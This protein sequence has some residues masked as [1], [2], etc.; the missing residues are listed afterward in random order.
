[1]KNKMYAGIMAAV[2]IGLLSG[3]SVNASFNQGNSV[4]FNGQPVM[5]ILASGGGFSPERR[6]W[7]AQDALDNAL[8]LSNDPGPQSVSVDLK[9]GA[10]VVNFDGHYIATADSGSAM[11]AGMSPAALANKWADSLKSALNDPDQ[12]RDYVASLK[13]PHQL[14]G[15]VAVAYERTIYAPQGT[16]LPVSFNEALNVSTLRSGQQ[17]TARVTANVP[18]GNYFIPGNSVLMGYVFEPNP[19]SFSVRINQLTTPNGTTL[20][21]TAVLTDRTS[22]V[23]TSAHPVATIGMPANQATSTRLPATIGIGTS[24]GG[25]LTAMIINPDRAIGSGELANVVLEQT[26]TVAARAGLGPM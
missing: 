12:T 19:G 11:A 23:S 17:V 14:K 10:Y 13:N 20:P 7:Q 6:A 4:T 15:D 18:V 5:S 8:F 16:I 21:I 9:N 24:N 22:L 26:S 1:M 25:T 2:T 3:N